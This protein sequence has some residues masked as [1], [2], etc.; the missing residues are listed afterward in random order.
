MLPR[1]RRAGGPLIRDGAQDGRNQCSSPNSDGGTIQAP[2][3]G[4][5]VASPKCVP[6]PAAGSH[7]DPEVGRCIC[8]S[9]RRGP[10]VVPR[11]VYGIYFPAARGDLFAERRRTELAN[12]WPTTPT[13]CSTGRRE[14]RV[15][16]KQSASDL[17][18]S[19]GS[20]MPPPGRC[21]H[22]R[23]PWTRSVP[24]R[25]L[26]ESSTAAHTRLTVLTDARS[27][28]GCSVG[29]HALRRPSHRLKPEH[30]G[31][32]SS[33]ASSFVGAGRP[34]VGGVWT[35]WPRNWHADRGPWT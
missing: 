28:V 7:A 17:D 22:R 4:P 32:A 19:Y 12:G 6:R 35:S 2:G 18:W 10:H 23:T 14:G 16:E 25:S 21:A 27:S 15:L 24:R 11:P 1:C 26:I 31:R 30:V 5:G 9:F 13:G 29:V 33:G 34:N 20:R 3:V 8:R